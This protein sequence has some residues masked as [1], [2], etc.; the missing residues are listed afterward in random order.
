MTPQETEP[1]LPASVR[2]F[3]YR[4]LGLSITGPES[5]PGDRVLDEVEKDNFIALPGKGGFCYVST[6][7]DMMKGF[8]TVVQRWGL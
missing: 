2:G 1:D 3:C 4:K 6:P 8:I 7:E 5:N